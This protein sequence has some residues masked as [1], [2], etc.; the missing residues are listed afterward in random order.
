MELDFKN[1][2][3]MDVQW[4]WGPVV[5]C[6]PIHVEIFQSSEHFRFLR[7]L[8][9]WEVLDLSRMS[10]GPRF[11][12]GEG[13]RP[14]LPWTY[15]F[16][17]WFN[18]NN[19]FNQSIF[20]YFFISIIQ[21]FDILD[22]FCIYLSSLSRFFDFQQTIFKN[23]VKNVQKCLLFFNLKCVKSTDYE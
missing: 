11:G 19:I 7:R 2:K 23:E 8:K 22:F 4:R 21:N 13:V 5:A 1:E 10:G 14:L 9:E 15:I 17:L 20:T 6:R 3:L 18:D 16:Y 12:L